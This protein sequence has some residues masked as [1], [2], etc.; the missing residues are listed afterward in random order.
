[1]MGH[2]NSHVS[3]FQEE[4]ETQNPNVRDCGYFKY[5]YTDLESIF[6][7]S[8]AINASYRIT[9]KHIS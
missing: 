8:V 9:D 1:M 5:L 6:K 7:Q 4:L 3:C 2:L